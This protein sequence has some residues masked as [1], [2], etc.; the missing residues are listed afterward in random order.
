MPTEFLTLSTGQRLAMDQ[1]GAPDGE[2]VFFCHGWPGSR[3]QAQRLDAAGREFNLRLISFDRPGIGL[4][5]ASGPRRLLDWPALLDAAADQLKI[6]K[7]RIV[8][9][10]GGGP[11][12]LVTAWARPERVLAAATVCGAPPI[13]ELADRRQLMAAYRLL[14]KLHDANPEV[15]RWLF[16]C[17]RPLALLHVPLALRP[18]I[19]RFV[20]RADAEALAD[21]ALFHVCFE[22]ARECWLGSAD[23]VFDDALIHAVPWGFA[24]EEIRVPIHVWHGRDDGNFA[25][26]LAEAMAARIPGA[27]VRIVENEGHYSLPFRQA[28]AILGA[29]RQSSLSALSV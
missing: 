24:L 5:P 14:L 18:L 7:F 29:F 26:P 6:D 25:S 1:Y 9:V 22:T 17:G 10:S 21:D 20:S 19:R 2:P 3:G 16:R 27:Q 8:G 12:A 13:A 23:G 11:Y 15:V 4:S 28:R